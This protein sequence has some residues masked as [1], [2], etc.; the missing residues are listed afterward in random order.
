MTRH[1]IAGAA[2]LGPISRSESREV[3][4]ARMIDLLKQ[5]KSRGCRYV[6]FPEMALTT[7]FARWYMEDEAELDS[8][9]ETEMPGP[10]TQPLFDMAAQLGVGF[11]LGYAELA[12]EDGKKKRYNTAVIANERG[13]II[14]KY[15]K[16]HIPGHVE[17][18][19][20]RSVQHLEKRYFDPGNFGFPVWREF[21]GIVGMCLCY[22]R[23]WPETFRVMGLQGVELVAVGYNT[24]AANRE[25]TEP[26]HLKM[27]HNHIVMQ[28]AAY[29]NGT[30]IIASAKA[31]NEDGFD[32][33]G[34]SCIIS[35]AGEIV[36]RSH[37]LDDELITHQCDLDLCKY[38]K[39]TVFNFAEYRQPESYKRIVDQVG[40]EYPPKAE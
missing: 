27:F 2:Q 29:Q 17:F 34:G 19:P 40:V 7:F 38:I 18:L 37:S 10:K 25:A 26:N 3:V 31:G 9:Y 28:A 32:M 5:A 35:P 39:E 36:A 6:V 13:Q 20:K 11:Y 8:F 24:P 12:Y 1:I 21:D 22:D 30:W 15:R 33:L 14:G 23:R 16:V 4:V